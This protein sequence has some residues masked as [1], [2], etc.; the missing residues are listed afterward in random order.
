VVVIIIGSQIDSG[1]SPLELVTGVPS[2]IVKA[3]AAVGIAG[4]RRQMLDVMALIMPAFDGRIRCSVGIKRPPSLDSFANGSICSSSASAWSYLRGPKVPEVCKSF[5]RALVAR[6]FVKCC[7]RPFGLMGMQIRN[8]LTSTH[9]VGM[10]NV[11]E[12]QGFD[13]WH[14]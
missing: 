1:P 12:T 14:W 2:A 7:R 3:T 13:I 5:V 10:V 6:Q 8:L 9:V 11:D 4:L